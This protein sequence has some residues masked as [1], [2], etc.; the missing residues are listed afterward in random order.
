MQ[1]E[2]NL[3][4]YVITNSNFRKK[5]AF[6]HSNFR[7]V[8]ENESRLYL[9]IC[10]KPISRVTAIEEYDV[11]PVLS[12]ISPTEQVD[13]TEDQDIEKLSFAK[14]YEFPEWVTPDYHD[15]LHGSLEKYEN[16]KFILKE[17]PAD[18]VE[19]KKEV[20]EHQSGVPTK[21]ERNLHDSRRIC[22]ISP[23]FGDFDIITNKQKL[24]SVI[25]EPNDPLTVSRSSEMVLGIINYDDYIEN[26]L[27]IHNLRHEE[28][29]RHNSKNNGSAQYE[30][31]TPR[32]RKDSTRICPIGF[33]F[34]NY[35]ISITKSDFTRHVKASGLAQKSPRS[36]E[37]VIRVINYDDYLENSQDNHEML[38]EERSPKRLCPVRSQCG[39]FNT[40]TQPELKD[41]TEIEGNVQLSKRICP[42]GSK[43]GD[44]NISINMPNLIL[45]MDFSDN[46]PAALRLSEEVI[47]VVNYDDFLTK[48]DGIK[49][50]KLKPSGCKLRSSKNSRINSEMIADPRRMK[51]DISGSPD[52]FIISM[53]FENFETLNAANSVFNESRDF[54]PCIC[55]ESTLPV[56]INHSKNSEVTSGKDCQKVTIVTSNYELVLYADDPMIRSIIYNEQILV[57]DQ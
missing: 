22:P 23:K 30:T 3:P 54:G 12:P 41:G 32:K 56:A 4:E 15:D 47:R 21:A 9:N 14:P 33:K 6:L 49:I 38:V 36:S 27:E 42:I 50:N 34:G 46:A 8:A 28:P 11:T 55:A 17:T 1:N 37:E 39:N 53:D 13:E 24:I 7:G 45:N 19:N 20:E 16:V 5:T 18:F 57:L 31:E 43:F 25:N 48:C 35:K 40:M 29:A 10:S 44:F 52:H 26:N 51:I 2:R